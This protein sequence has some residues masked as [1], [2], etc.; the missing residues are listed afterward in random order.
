MTTIQESSRLLIE[1]L[2]E[3]QPENPISFAAEFF[4]HAAHDRVT[5]FICRQRLTSSKIG[6]GTW[7]SNIGAAYQ[8]LNC[9]NDNGFDSIVCKRFFKSISSHWKEITSDAFQTAIDYQLR[10]GEIVS[11][12]EFEY[13]CI[14]YVLIDFILQNLDGSETNDR[15]FYNV[16]ESLIFRDILDANLEKRY[17]EIA[18]FV[19]KCAQRVLLVKS[20]TF[21]SFLA[22]LILKSAQLH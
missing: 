7:I 12:Q 20:E 13:D 10:H 11:Y 9:A 1:L 16:L 3:L 21:D 4:L 18:N 5:W 2:V 22:D 17:N 14:L 6:T 19:L 15:N 8:L